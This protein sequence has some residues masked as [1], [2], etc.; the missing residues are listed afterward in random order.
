MCALGLVLVDNYRTARQA[1]LLEMSAQG[2]L[3]AE[4]A[5]A[6]LT[7]ND[8]AG[9]VKIV[10]KF[11][12]V[13]SVRGA[14]ITDP[15]GRVLVSFGS[16]QEVASLMT[17]KHGFHDDFLDITLPIIDHDERIGTLHLR[18]TTAR[19]YQQALQNVGFIA[20]VLVVFIG[21][22]WLLARR[23]YPLISKPIV[24]LAET[25]RQI[26]QHGDYSVRVQPPPS[27][28]EI[29]VLYQQFNAMLEQIDTHALQRDEAL[30]A[31][32]EAKERA[33]VT[34]RSIADA[35]IVTDVR[36][37]IEYLNPAAERLTGWSDESARGMPV[38]RI[39]EVRVAET[40]EPVVPAIV[41]C[42]SEAR[43][44]T[45]PGE[46]WLV[47]S[48]G[49]SLAVE[50]T[51]AP[52]HDRHGNVVGGV[53][54]FRDV[55]RS[56][57]LAHEIRHQAQHDDL[58]GLFN[59]RALEARLER[60]LQRTHQEG[61]HHVLLFMDLDRFKIVNDSCGHLAGDEM[62]RQ[63][64]ALL[65]VRLRARDTLARFGGDEFA[66][67]LEHC[68]AEEAYQIADD[69]RQALQDY[70]YTH[71]PHTFTVGVSTGLVPL[72]QNSGSL[73][74]VL[75]LGDA[76]CY[77]A[78]EAGRNLIHRA[79][80]L[81][82][83]VPQR[84]DT[85][86]TSR[87]VKAL[88]ENKFRLAWQ[89][90]V[91]TAQNDHPLGAHYEILLRLAGE[92][93]TLI[94]PG[95]FLSTAE[96]YDLIPQIDRWVI[97]QTLTWLTTHPRRAR[98]IN[99]CSINLSGHA[100]GDAKFLDYVS[101]QLHEFSPVANKICFEITE[102]ATLTHLC[103]AKRFLARLREQ[104]CRFALDDFGTGMRSFHY[105][106]DL[107]V[108]YLKIDGAFVRH[109]A[110]DAMDYAMVRSINEIGHLMSMQT[111]AECVETTEV[112]ERLRSIGIDYCQ[113][114]AIA[115]PT[116][117]EDWPEEY[118]SEIIPFPGRNVVGLRAD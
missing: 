42:L 33:L 9:M 18:A 39:Y 109:L 34:L 77:A 3:I 70:R 50:D 44:L 19:V 29:G 43:A 95:A 114:Y 48:D 4:Y 79:D 5:I 17:A 49:R 15:T 72:D 76:A 61:G 36:G 96:R 63:I 41:R 14:A 101:A 94:L 54:V 92:G 53:L 47:C 1:L 115:H 110:T 12:T 91:P 84:Q 69:L 16:A 58:T 2:R 88:Q 67:L 55:T 27:K 59:R 81:Y 40:Q 73:E 93:G 89:R 23:L 38:E 103:S 102:T 10:D 111:I 116:L 100:L 118:S 57:H 30:A 117:L 104:G 8:H 80:H 82:S 37:T 90:I 83:P 28:D 60:T 13:P 66:A 62:L 46:A 107:P 22:A 35:V 85:Q 25:A 86:G 78:K 65:R 71:G 51:A 68:T 105:L 99:M 31:L 113:G 64:S 75:R 106:K 21:V 32:Y 26:S 7:F 97:R 98:D 52:L 56:R 45:T 11:A 24:Q 112:R 87:L 108:N 74:E 20:L 6:P